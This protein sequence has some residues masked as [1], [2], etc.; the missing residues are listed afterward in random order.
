[1]LIFLHLP[2]TAGTT[3]NDILRRQY[4]ERGFFYA[5]ADVR[6]EDVARRLPPTLANG[7]GA[8]DVLTGHFYFGLHDYLPGVSLIPYIT[9]LRDPVNRF[10]SEY[11]HVLRDP[12]DPL[13]AQVAVRRMGLDAYIALCRKL[14][15]D[16]L[17]TR[18]LSGVPPGGGD[19][20][21]CLAQAQE[22]I[23]RHFSLAGLT[24]DMDNALVLLKRRYG[25]KPP[26]YARANVSANPVRAQDIAPQDLQAIQECHT[27]DARLY[28]WVAARFQNTLAAQDA[29]FAAD[30]KR[31]QAANR[32]WAARYRLWETK[33]KAMGARRRG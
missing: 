28:A 15:R 26:Y 33:E 16:N 32:V 6:P 27:F 11:S 4:G 14:G 23:A 21:G 9:L 3:L 5:G 1:M 7:A 20:E 18:M 29:A 31:F 13:H 8:M 10:L 22:N 30:V 17:Q 25:W 12:A 24:E 2:K 19:L